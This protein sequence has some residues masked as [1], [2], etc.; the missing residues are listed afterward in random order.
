M[1]KENK[2]NQDIG[3]DST[4]GTQSATAKGGVRSAKTPF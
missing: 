1:A 3:R 2:N 4:F